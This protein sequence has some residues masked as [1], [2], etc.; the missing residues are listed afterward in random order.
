MSSLVST[1]TPG[2][3]CGQGALT[4]LERAA[5]GGCG[6]KRRG[7]ERSRGERA[8]REQ[9]QWR[10]APGRRRTGGAPR[11]FCSEAG[12]S[13][14]REA[15]SGGDWGGDAG[16]GVRAGEPSTGRPPRCR[17]RPSASRR[18]RRRR[19]AAGGRLRA[20]LTGEGVSA[21]LLAVVEETN[22]ARREQAAGVR[23]DERAPLRSFCAPCNL[24]KVPP[25]ATWANERGPAEAGPAA[26]PV[27]GACPFACGAPFEWGLR[28]GER[29]RGRGVRA[30]AWSGAR[31]LQAGRRAE[32]HRDK[33]TT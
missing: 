33:V 26:A 1:D 22:V 24:S 20:C 7:N 12:G 27:A 16:V 25:T 17:D 15:A 19:G 14:G 3:T 9:S 23:G 21:V 18:A 30:R 2:R 13:G 8:P 5:G 32:G 28:R 29:V 11:L 4:S 10:P 6:G 31:G